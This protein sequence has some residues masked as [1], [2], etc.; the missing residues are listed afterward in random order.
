M[1]EHQLPDDSSIAGRRRRPWGRPMTGGA[2]DQAAKDVDPVGLWKVRVRH[3][4]SCPSSAVGR[5]LPCGNGGVSFRSSADGR[6]ST[7]SVSCSAEP[8]RCPTRWPQPVAFRRPPLEGPEGFELT[9]R[10]HDLPPKVWPGADTRSLPPEKNDTRTTHRPAP[11]QSPVP[12]GTRHPYS[13]DLSLRIV[14]CHPLK[15]QPP[16]TLR[17][18]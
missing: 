14:K 1:T 13:H 5:R 12:E 6:A 16:R 9:A 10:C 7:T 15:L 11:A 8:R 2:G 4:R 17:R 18:M 3:G